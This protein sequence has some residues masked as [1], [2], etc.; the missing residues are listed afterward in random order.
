M[1]IIKFIFN[2]S[3]NSHQWSTTFEID[4]VY[5]FGVAI[6]ASDEEEAKTKAKVWA[7]R[8]EKARL[9]K[10]AERWLR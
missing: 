2:D 1:V 10:A 6:D 3:A 4:G 5:A 9:G 7:A 8:W